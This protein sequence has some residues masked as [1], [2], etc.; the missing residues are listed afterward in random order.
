MLKTFKNNHIKNHNSTSVLKTRAKG[1]GLEQYMNERQYQKLNSLLIWKLI[2]N[3]SV[4]DVSPKV[5]N[6]F[7]SEV[8]EVVFLVK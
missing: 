4:T 5:D 8:V 1:S 2:S 6:Y 7:V 3:S